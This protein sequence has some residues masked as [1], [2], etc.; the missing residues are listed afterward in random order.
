MAWPLVIPIIESAPA[1]LPTVGKIL[2]TTAAS[3]A[4]GAAG[5]EAVN[6]YNRNKIQSDEETKR[7]IE[8]YLARKEAGKQYV[9]E[10]ITNIPAIDG[11]QKIERQQIRIVMPEDAIMIAKKK[12][13]KAQ[14]KPGAQSKPE[15][16]PTPETT[17]ENEQASTAEVAQEQTTT[18]TAT[19]QTVTPK[20]EKPD[21]STK[22]QGKKQGLLSRIARYPGKKLEQAG[23]ALQEPPSKLKKPVSKLIIGETIG[24]GIIDGISNI[25]D[26]VPGYQPQ[27]IWY[28]VP[29]ATW[30]G[31]DV[32]SDVISEN[33]NKKYSTQSGQTS[34]TTQ[35]TTQS[36]P[37]IYT[38][39]QVDS[40]I[41][42]ARQKR[43]NKFKQ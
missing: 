38:T 42:A 8:E 31:V 19:T 1:W 35:S 29:G 11:K 9:L 30:K 25:K 22:N 39:E 37:Q 3:A 10:Q 40:T 16:Q 13:P 24:A 14:P 27:A 6:Q 12:K 5:A 21:D 43:P 36:T 2:G 23:K 15:E 32:I 28:T 26:T 18:Q 17:A 7:F 20:P 41:N 34:S 33:T 4:V